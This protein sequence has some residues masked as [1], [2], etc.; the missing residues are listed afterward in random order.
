MKKMMAVGVLVTMLFAASTGI[1]QDKVVVTEWQIPFLNC[2]TGPLAS[3]GSMYQWSTN[4]AAADINKAGG[5]AG[6]PVKV[7]GVDTAND[8]QK[9]TVEMA[10]LHPRPFSHPRR[11]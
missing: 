7:I 3:H 11:P 2:L 9:G 4:Q 6:K 5:I 8:P 10:R 1:A